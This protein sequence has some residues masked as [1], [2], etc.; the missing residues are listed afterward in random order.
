MSD[1]F[2]IGVI[3][4]THIPDRVKAIPKKAFEALITMDLVIHA[5]DMVTSEILELFKKSFHKVVAVKGN[6][7]EEQLQ[8]TLLEKEIITVEGIRIGVT[9]GRGPAHHI[10][11]TVKEVFKGEALDI[12]I[13][14][15]SH[16]PF[17]QT[18]DATLY[19]NPGSLTDT[20]YAPYNS[21][22]VIEIKNNTIDARIIKL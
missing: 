21:Y 18:I 2:T 1:T 8:N 6:M 15:H 17:N 4:D 14:G 3:S 7:D 19:F 22:G 13:F 11:E 20:L 5:G 16:T 12:I 9:H 10:L